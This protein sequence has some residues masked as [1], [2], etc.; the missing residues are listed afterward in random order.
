MKLVVPVVMASLVAACV[1]EQE[2]FPVDAAPPIDADILTT[3][4]YT[5]S[6]FGGP[7]SG[8]AIP[9]WEVRDVQ[10]YSAPYG[11]PLPGDPFLESLATMWP[12]HTHNPGLNYLLSN[13][14]HV[15]HEGEVSNGLRAANFPTGNSYTRADWSNGRGLFV[16]AVIV[17]I[18][19]APSGET[20]D[21]TPL[22]LIAGRMEYSGILQAPSGGDDFGAVFPNA[23]NTTQTGADGWSH[24]PFNIA[25]SAEELDVCSTCSD[26][27]P[28]EYF[29]RFTFWQDRDFNFGCEIMIPFTIR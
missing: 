14:P 7:A 19:G 28:G 25:T 8:Y 27:G 13:T 5:S 21:G 2:P 20:A 10:L 4:Q 26:G 29:F 17:P 22:P 6:C 11:A 3:T 9:T 16:S 1:P 18:A 12:Q 15:A 24:M 23:I